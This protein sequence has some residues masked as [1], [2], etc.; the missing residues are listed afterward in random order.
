MVLVFQRTNGLPV[1]PA[2]TYKD[3]QRSW[4]FDHR[5]KIYDWFFTV[6]REKLATFE[7]FVEWLVA[8]E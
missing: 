4:E 8:H 3:W 1:V 2:S 7:G 5:R 6:A